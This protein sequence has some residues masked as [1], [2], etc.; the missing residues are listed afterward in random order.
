ME[1]PTWKVIP[2]ALKKYHVN[3]PAE[4]YALHLLYGNKERCLR[5]D[6]K[7]LKL[8][9]QLDKEGK[10]PMFMLRKIVAVSVARPEPGVQEM[11]GHDI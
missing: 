3:A 4:N 2:A 1:D 11:T 6:E 9:K 10:K 7:P 5:M 8:F